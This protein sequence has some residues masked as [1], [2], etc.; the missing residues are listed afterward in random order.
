VNP[1]NPH[2]NR[3]L[4]PALG[5]LALGI[6]LPS[7]HAQLGYRQTNLVSDIPGVAAHTDPNL[8]NPWGISESPGSPFW[9]SDNG[10]GVSTLYTTSGAPQSLVVT[11]PKVGGGTSA[12]T[13]TVFNGGTGFNSNLF[14]FASEDGA[15]T[16]WRPALGT[17]A[18]V[19]HDGSSVGAVY[20]GLAISTIGANSYLYASDFHND[21]ITVLPSSG[22]PAL[23]GTF[24]DPNLPAGYAP[25]NVQNL[26]GQLY[27]T[28][29]K[30][31]AAGHDDVPGLGNGYVDV[32]DLNGNLVKRLVSNGLLDSPW[33]LAIAPSGFGSVSGD[34]LVGNF[35]NGS[36]DAY[37]PTSGAFL[38]AL[39]DPSGNP[40]VI[41]GLWALTF[42]NGG[43]GGNKDTLYFTAGIPGN[44]SIEDHGLFGSLSPVPE[45]A[46]TG[47]VASAA[48]A[49]LC[50]VT[51]FRRGRAATAG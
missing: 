38:G 24:A 40:L 45:P 29:A 20:K 9:V 42:G 23:T 48:L 32:F 22:A 14:L 39:D 11:I 27:V 49:C 37:D 16:G 35:G 18:E 17:N 1:Q 51:W 19:V 4:A 47:L 26:G 2:W 43:S 6:S 44:G 50:A 31:D 12:P 7:L 3:L 25:F 33:G 10:T 30:Q 15:V 34:L 13:G 5:A 8:V 46:T 36:I 28:F 21:Q 41:P